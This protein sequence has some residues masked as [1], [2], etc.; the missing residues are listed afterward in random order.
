MPLLPSAL[1][2]Q[3]P[4]D[5]CCSL[6][7]QRCFH[8]P[9]AGFASCQS[10]LDPEGSFSASSHYHTPSLVISH[11]GYYFS[12]A[13]FHSLE[14]LS[15]RYLRHCLRHASRSIPGVF[16]H[17]GTLSLLR[18][19]KSSALGIRLPLERRCLRCR[20]F[21]GLLRRWY[22][23]TSSI[24]F[25]PYIL[26]SCRSGPRRA[27]PTSASSVLHPFHCSDQKGE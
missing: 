15:F 17:S 1:C 10:P 19:G 23:F 12:P 24:Y 21:P 11:L 13:A 25:L 2:A 7:G 26:M 9:R 22:R 4:F 5:V 8:C 18:V 27:L 16:L 3:P 20:E 6:F 14:D